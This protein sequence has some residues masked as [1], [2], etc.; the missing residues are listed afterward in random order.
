MS[1]TS[2]AKAE[3]TAHKV[4]GKSLRSLLSAFLR[5][6]A[7][8]ESKNGFFGFFVCGEAVVIEYIARCIYRK[9]GE[10]PDVIAD[11]SKPD[12][13]KL[14]LINERSA[15][16]LADLGIL[17]IGEDV[18]VL[19]N[20]EESLVNGSA[21]FKAFLTGAF[22]G[23][24]SVTVPELDKTTK[25]SYHVEFVF[26]KYVTASDFCSV[27]AQNKFF[28]KLVERKDKFVVYFKSIEEI[29]RILGLCGANASYLRLTDIQI[30]KDIKNS[31]N[32]KQNCEMS[33]LNKVVNA[34]VKQKE[35]IRL[36]NEVIGLDMLPE[37]LYIVAK[38]RLENESMS[39][40][41]LA[42]LL[43]L[44]KSCLV[45]RLNKISE[46]AKSL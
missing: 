38:A 33:N 40:S 2:S 11:S 43:G 39:Y 35:E 26:S 13:A 4:D 28:P 5:T 17:K 16:I 31:E 45:H 25:T 42:E 22:L 15:D 46:I 21:S 9:Y 27:L 8:I 37:Q 32:R 3:I 36:I 23:A 7:T 24:G 1:F 44:T 18:E 20:I 14:K 19:L 6:A 29:E 12:R 34:T 30:K 10:K 41:E